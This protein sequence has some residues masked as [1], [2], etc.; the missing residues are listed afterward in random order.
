MRR[1]R[2]W[3]RARR[4]GKLIAG[5]KSHETNLLDDNRR[6][7]LDRAGWMLVLFEARLFDWL[8]ENHLRRRDSL[9]QQRELP[10]L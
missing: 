1:R 10:S 8:S 4:G 5:A 9:D 3:R 2:R 6:A 7:V